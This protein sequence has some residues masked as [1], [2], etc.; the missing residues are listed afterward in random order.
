[1]DFG[2][3]EA[4][5]PAW[6]IAL[7]PEHQLVLRGRIDRVD[8]Y[9]QGERVFCVVMDY[10]SSVRKLDKILLGHGI[11][12]QLL[13]YLAAVRRWPAAFFQAK[14]LVP[15]GVFYVN[16]RGQFENTGSREEAL[17]NADENRRMAYRHQGRFNAEHLTQLDRAGTADQFNYRLT[18][19][20]KIHGNSA[21]A[22]SCKDFEGLLDEVE[23]KLRVIGQRIFAGEAKVDPYRK[24]NATACEYCDY[25]AVC[26]IDPW[27]HV[28]RVLR[29]VDPE[30]SA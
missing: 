30:E 11:Q 8:I 13:G 18:K 28:W 12:L 26:R 24:G 20:G 29:A 9:R 7:D 3:A 27:T 15:S 14:E 16:L 22:L 6:E 19:E 10:K 21:E 1:L 23:E 4:G 5:A 2:I 25:R 17:G